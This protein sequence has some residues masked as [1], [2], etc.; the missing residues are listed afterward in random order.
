[1][2]Q[3]PL[4]TGSKII[5]AFI[6]CALILLAFTLIFGFWNKAARETGLKVGIICSEDEAAPYSAAVEVGFAID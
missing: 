3:K 5:A 2:K 4:K 1:M 6:M